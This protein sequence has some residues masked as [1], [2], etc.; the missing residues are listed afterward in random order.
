MANLEHQRKK[1]ENQLSILETKIQEAEKERD[2]ALA[3]QKD[4]S[5]KDPR[6]K[7]KIRE[8]EQKLSLLRNDLKQLQQ[9]KIEN[10]KLSRREEAKSRELADAKMKL[11]E[12]KRQKVDLI[13]KM[14]DDAKIF[15]EKEMKTQKELNKLKKSMRLTETNAAAANLKQKSTEEKLQRSE[16]AVNELKLQL[17]NVK[18]AA[19]KNANY[20]KMWSVTQQKIR[21]AIAARET[22]KDVE[23]ELEKLLAE[24]KSLE[25]DKSF[26]NDEHVEYISERIQEAQS[27]L[28]ELADDEPIVDVENASRSQLIYLLNQ[29]VPFF[30]NAHANVNQEKRQMT[31]NYQK[32][33]NELDSKE[34][35]FAMQKQL[36]SHLMDKKT[37]RSD[38]LPTPRTASKKK[39]TANMFGLSSALGLPGPSGE[40]GDESTD[41][42]PSPTS[43]ISST[44]TGSSKDTSSSSKLSS[45]V[46]GFF[47]RN[48]S[49]KVTVDRAATGKFLP[50]HSP[51]DEDNTVGLKCTQALVGH[52]K[53]I[54][55]IV[56]S[57]E[58]LFT[59]G[60]DKLI[61]MWD[62]VDDKEV[63]QYSM[64][65]PVELLAF[66]SKQRILYTVDGGKVSA[67][68][69]ETGNE[70]PLKVITENK[71]IQF[72][73]T[74]DCGRL[75]IAVDKTVKCYVNHLDTGLR[76]ASPSEI[77]ALSVRTVSDLEVSVA[78]GG[79][80]NSTRLFRHSFELP[81]DSIA[82]KITLSPHLDTVTAI[83]E[84]EDFI[85]TG[86][87]DNSIKLWS[88]KGELVK[89][90]SMAHADWILSMKIIPG[91]NAFVSVARD[92]SLAIWSTNLEKIGHI[93]AADAVAVRSIGTTR[94]HVFTGSPVK[95][96]G[97]AWLICF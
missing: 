57:E 87:R 56:A 5:D 55:S 25:D 41:R 53:A 10:E 95:K 93:T 49:S 66:D 63:L 21:S 72:V 77:T 51:E 69:T 48:S 35:Y 89:T 90:F 40:N 80:D 84:F 78:V 12:M 45:R 26:Q 44:E 61:K 19:S 34:S 15:K 85:A 18:N 13:K 6:S 36:I 52:Q 31:A 92:G 71:P 16:K 59:S 83:V 94:T 43:T 42:S 46:G 70:K 37:S 58:F 39:R 67:W 68:D 32:V 88:S 7:E 75:W 96:S 2:L 33:Q 24:R 23:N 64:P 14:R 47:S 62:L 50:S 91:R 22:Q 76:C 27:Q 29:M 4:K 73:E 60:R 9:Q 3:K 82:P 17:K 28:V 1:Y 11:Q 86:S 97:K 38:P 79:R 81:A 30:V 54:I 65:S 20:S 8:M 74:D